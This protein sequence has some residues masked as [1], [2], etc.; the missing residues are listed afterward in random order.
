MMMTGGSGFPWPV[1]LLPVLV[2]VVVSMVL[3]IRFGLERPYR[4]PRRLPEGGATALPAP[5]DPMVILRERLVR[6][7]ID[8]PEFERRLEGLLRSDPKEEM[9]WWNKVPPAPRRRADG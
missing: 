2:V 9:P 1:V 3:A 6:G 8:L 5:R 7:E 4:A